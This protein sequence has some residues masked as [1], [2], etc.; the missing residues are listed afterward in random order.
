MLAYSARRLLLGTAIL[1]FVSAIVF[2]LTN[3]AVDPAI[4]LAGEGATAADVAEVRNQCGLDRPILPILVRYAAWL[5]AAAG[6]DFGTSLKQHRPVAQVVLERLPVT[7]ALGCAALAVSLALSLPLALL[8]AVRPGSAID[9][10]GLA[11][12]LLGQA[13][14]SF[15]LALIAI[16]VFS[17]ELGWLPASGSTQ[18]VMFI[19][20]AVVLGFYATPP[21]LRLTRA[22]LIEVLRAD[23]IRTARAK[24]LRPPRVL[25][26]HALSNAVIPV[27]SIAAVQ[28]GYLLGGSVVIE[29]IFAMNG[30]GYL[31]WQAVSDG[32]LPVIEALVL[33]TALFY[34]I[35]TLTADLLNAWL[36]P[37]I[38]LA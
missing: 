37:R 24:G 13:M 18:A 6:G 35:L 10:F 29:T 2:A 5:G 34:V 26:R 7:V 15:W 16:L 38:R 28:F 23:Y 22:G 33:V 31:A 8:A 19:M 30:I 32:D 9:R 25:I 14:P 20:P 27:I 21:I 3:V 1:L 36:D 11:L 17:V 12:A 4:T